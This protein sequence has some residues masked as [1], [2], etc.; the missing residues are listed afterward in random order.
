[1]PAQ[2]FMVYYDNFNR[3]FTARLDGRSVPIHRANFTFKAIALPAGQHV[4]EWSF[5]PYPVKIIWAVFYASL[6]AYAFL[7]RRFLKSPRGSE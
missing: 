7:L 3:F 4:V 5:N 6:F 2:G 1:M